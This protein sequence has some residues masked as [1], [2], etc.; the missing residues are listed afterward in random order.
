MI[1]ALST[2]LSILIFL[3]G[4]VLAYAS[5]T[6][7]WKERAQVAALPTGF[8]PD[9]AQ[10]FKQ[11]P[12]PQA[13]T[14]SSAIPKRLE[15]SIP[16]D[17][18]KKL[19][20]VLKALSANYG[21]VRKIQIGP[22]P[23]TIVHIQDIHQNFEAQTNI[24]KTV[25]GLIDKNA[26]G[27]I[28]L[29]GAF[30]GIDLNEFRSFPNKEATRILADYLLREN[31]VSGPVHTALTSPSKIPAIS[32][33]DDKTL[34]NHN[35]QSYQGS[36][37]KVKALKNELERANRELASAKV[38]L[39]PLLAS[40]QARVDSYQAGA[41]PIGEYVKILAEE[42]ATT[43]DVDVF[44]AAY[45]LE[46]TIDFARVEQER[47]S[48]LSELLTKLN[49][50]ETDDLLN[51][52]IAYR[53]GS[54]N[55]TDFYGYLKD[56]CAKNHVQLSRFKAM[57]SYVRYVLLTDGINPEKLFPAIS[58]MEKENYAQLISTDAERDYVAKS[59][60]LHLTSKLI[61]F[62]LTP[63]EWAAYRKSNTLGSLDLSSFERFYEMA[64]A[65]NHAIT[66]NLL[67][68]MD[69]NRTGVAVLVTG[70]FHSPGIDQLLKEAG[71]TTITFVPKLTKV[72]GENGAAY[73][74]VFAQEK[75]PLD[76]LFSG[77]KLFVAKNPGENLP[78]NVMKAGQSAIVENL[79]TNKPAI[80]RKGKTG[81][82]VF[83]FAEGHV[84][85]T[86]VFVAAGWGIVELLRTQA[87]AQMVSAI[88][89]SAFFVPAMLLTGVALVVHV[90]INRKAFYGVR[91]TSAILVATVATF[92]GS[93]LATP[94]A[95]VK[96]AF[97]RQGAWLNVDG[98]L[99]SGVPAYAYQPTPNGM[100]IGQFE[101]GNLA[102]LYK[103][104]LPPNGQGIDSQKYPN[105]VRLAQSPGGASAQD[106]ARLLAENGAKLIRTYN[107]ARSTEED[108]RL[109][110]E[111]YRWM[112]DTYKIS[113]VAGMYSPNET[114]IRMVGRLF[115]DH[116]GLLFYD[117]W[118]EF[119]FRGG[120]VNDVRE[121]DQLAGI[122]KS[123]DPNHP[124]A[125][126]ISQTF[127]RAIGDAIKEAQ[128][129]DIVG[130]T[131]YNRTG[132]DAARYIR[133]IQEGFFPKAVI[134]SEIGVRVDAASPADRADRLRGIA[135]SLVRTSS[136]QSTPP[137]VTWFEFTPEQW[138]GQDNNWWFIDGQ[139]Q[140]VPAYGAVQSVQTN[141][142]PGPRVSGAV[143]N[144]TPELMREFIQR[145]KQGATQPSAST[146]AG[147]TFPVSVTNVQVIAQ[148]FDNASGPN[149]YAA[150]KG[151][152]WNFSQ[153]SLDTKLK[154]VFGSSA[155]GTKVMLRLLPKGSTPDS[156]DGSIERVYTVARE[157]DDGVIVVSLRDFPADVRGPV[158][159]IG[160]ASG[161]EAWGNSLGGNNGRVVPSRV[162]LIPSGTS[163]PAIR[164]TIDQPAPGAALPVEKNEVLTDG[165]G[166]ASGPNW[167]SAFKDGD[168]DLSKY[169]AGTKL[170][171]VFRSSAV[172]TKVVPR[173][174]P[175]RGAPESSAGALRREVTIERDGEEAAITVNLSDFPSNARSRISQISVAS[176]QGAWGRFL[177]AENGRVTPIRV[178]VVLPKKSGAQI[179]V[180][181]GLRKA[182]LIVGVLL[183]GF[184][185]LASAAT[186]VVSNN[187]SQSVTNA[188]AG[189]AEI[190]V[191]STGFG[192]G[193]I[194]VGWLILA[195]FVGFG[196]YVLVRWAIAA[197]RFNALMKST[198]RFEPPSAPKSASEARARELGATF[199][200]LEGANALTSAID[201]F[202]R[203]SAEIEKDK[204]MSPYHRQQSM[205]TVWDRVRT[206]LSLAADRLPGFEVEI[207]ALINSI[208]GKSNPVPM[209]SFQDP[210][211]L[212]FLHRST[213]DL[214]RRIA[215]VH[216]RAVSTS[217]P[218]S[219]LREGTSQR[220][221][222]R[223]LLLPFLISASLLTAF[224]ASAQPSNGLSSSD[225]VLE[226][227][228]KPVPNYP[229]GR[230]QKESLYKDMESTNQFLRV[231][232]MRWLSDIRTKEDIPL[233]LGALDD[234]ER[235]VRSY[236]V[237][238]LVGLE[239]GDPRI[240]PALFKRL[241]DEDEV[242]RSL[243]LRVLTKSPSRNSTLVE[244][245]AQMLENDPNWIVRH[246][247]A[248]GLGEMGPL[249][250][251]AIPRLK[252][253]INS[254]TSEEVNSYVGL[255]AADSL[256]KLGEN[257]DEVFQALRKGLD[258]RDP[259]VIP[260]ALEGLGYLGSKAQPVVPEIEKLVN[261]SRFGGF[262]GPIIKSAAQVA[263]EKITGVA[264]NEDSPVASVTNVPP[265][266][267]P[268]PSDFAAIAA[269][270]S[271]FAARRSEITL[272]MATGSVRKDA[273]LYDPLLS[274][275]RK[276]QEPRLRI[277]PLVGVAADMASLKMKEEALAV[278]KEAEDAAK[279][280]QVSL[281]RSTSL[282]TVVIGLSSAGFKDEAARVLESI[283]NPEYKA[284][285]KK[286]I[287]SKKIQLNKISPLP[288]RLSRVI[289]VAAV[290]LIAGFGLGSA[291]AQT[292]TNNTVTNAIPSAVQKIAPTILGMD[293]QFVG[294]MAL[295]VLFIF[296]ILGAY[297]LIH[298][299]A[300]R[301]PSRASLGLGILLR[302]DLKK[303]GVE[304]TVPSGFEPSESKGAPADLLALAQDA[305]QMVKGEPSGAALS[306]FLPNG[307]VTDYSGQRGI[308]ALSPLQQR[309]FWQLFKR[310]LAGAR[311]SL[312]AEGVLDRSF[313]VGQALTLPG[314]NVKDMPYHIVVP[315]F[316]AN[317]D[318]FAQKMADAEKLVQQGFTRVRVEVNKKDRSRIPALLAN[319]VLVRDGVLGDLSDLQRFVQHARN[320]Q[321]IHGTA[322]LA[323]ED[324]L[325]DGI[326]QEALFEDDIIVV[327]YSDLLK[328]TPRIAPLSVAIT[329]LMIVG[330]QT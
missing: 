216:E 223:S 235:L 14:F 47:A 8:S 61:D 208:P 51:T 95:V 218:R 126:V 79:Q 311:V 143:T 300:G 260:L 318:G 36:V 21:N 173:L 100:N 309:E 132:P 124:V 70:G 63:D 255:A 52:S 158:I 5:E 25:Q 292:L 34:Y 105:L 73:L 2:F 328:G 175:L 189:A 252:Q 287:E 164:P 94:A 245:V 46:S 180:P 200:W 222:V 207:G 273:R 59:K 237:L 81:A 285:L 261:A 54:I 145:Q 290:L 58:R 102:G 214:T 232:A 262:H 198:P 68:A 155:V 110:S 99:W 152:D 18:Q 313:E 27:L 258:H 39:N 42:A 134:V 219:D 182:T 23:H 284:G 139:N 210:E 74:S 316:A 305:V 267:T 31:R 142:I 49:K 176:G 167:F 226:L 325:F 133:S 322:V 293:F 50:D 291:G 141:W 57:D 265:A 190:A 87:L 20:P 174:L 108:L 156:P 194:L 236:A 116:P 118:N 75:T 121:I 243:A 53:V 294:I 88:F 106:H 149:W 254:D 217:Y 192:W 3:Q 277:N 276:I 282:G 78:A 179:N 60:R 303:Q 314:V 91:V 168:W 32:G 40:F 44:L 211:F 220:S 4:S 77:E 89:S 7:F 76:Q 122:L 234:P 297:A 272:K 221:L 172:G 288:S 65:R 298:W 127:R 101:Q 171:F 177:G 170:K 319:N 24:G 64:E 92:F 259:R 19:D 17:H 188:V 268:S 206:Y 72:D 107:L 37:S 204:K 157:G 230:I 35:I 12:S 135:S 275:I 69:K 169:P 321:S 16:E 26:V 264:R 86:I 283:E 227:L 270:Q 160:V 185:G 15:K 162:E 184:A 103:A 295:G 11:I 97:D 191:K 324:A 183:F 22:K 202:I 196:L 195:A 326:G 129:I 250:R 317:P 128:N 111:I 62:S 178:E 125:V 269:Q 161:Q 281:V 30:A 310:E 228:W 193:M 330:S 239:Q 199:K 84:L 231:I 241:S 244:K 248:L 286:I 215:N 274:D 114:S 279:T 43:P 249:A 113:F 323:V 296:I 229:V 187:A 201:F 13:Q 119:D 266:K 301:F 253:A 159:Q 163:A 154:F 85:E 246:N 6:N 150:F 33:I 263:L 186:N 9:P 82:L 131:I 112:W 90:A 289:G 1:R 242:T 224:S 117:G 136:A 71:A 56:L 306:R 205:N 225:L 312:P 148:A 147:V 251:S 137:V 213:Q 203:S 123:V 80:E 109:V 38:F 120:S 308:T 280:V 278:F 165:F 29:E 130:V 271:K 144:I 240:V 41:L 320:V 93:L 96:V 98:Q 153:Y 66:Q 28:G 307:R 247:A 233:L 329:L 257:Q 181:S 104:L 67:T 327:R 166:S 197:R 151:G 299:I 209:G 315:D 146:N 138:K 140:P 48:L 304:A 302:S 256:A 45:D 55:H 115:A 238:S 212:P 10:I 83:R